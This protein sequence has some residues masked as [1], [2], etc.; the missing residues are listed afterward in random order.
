[1]LLLLGPGTFDAS[2]GVF[3]RLAGF[4]QSLSEELSH[5]RAEEL[6]TGAV[7][8]SREGQFIQSFQEID[9]GHL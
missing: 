3:V 7:S 5:R 4:A 9:A 1:M 8:P 2:S 6:F